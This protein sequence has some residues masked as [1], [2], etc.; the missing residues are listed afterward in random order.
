MERVS[1]TVKSYILALKENANYNQH[2]DPRMIVVPSV[3][4][5]ALLNVEL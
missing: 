1:K 5:L 2:L 3:V 4:P